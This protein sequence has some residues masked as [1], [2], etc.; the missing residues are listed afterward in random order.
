MFLKETVKHNG[1]QLPPKNLFQYRDQLKK[2][3]KETYI[4]HR[5]ICSYMN[6]NNK[7]MKQSLR[8]KIIIKLRL[9]SFNRIKRKQH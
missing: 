4:K 1:W 8:N 3:N 6:R 7:P 9:L 5:F 2:E